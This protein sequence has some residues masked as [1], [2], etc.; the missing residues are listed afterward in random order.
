MLRISDPLLLWDEIGAR[1]RRAGRSW[2]VCRAIGGGRLRL[3]DLARAL[4]QG[5]GE[6]T[7]CGIAGLSPIL[8][9]PKAAEL[10]DQ[11]A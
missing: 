7:C 1:R 5:L 2:G 4:L 10:R 8:S 6:L 11:K 9:F 3:S